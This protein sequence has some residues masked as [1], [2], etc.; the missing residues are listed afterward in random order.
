VVTVDVGC[1]LSLGSL[2]CFVNG[3]KEC[4]DAQKRMT[5]NTDAAERWNSMLCEG[6]MARG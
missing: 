2:A 1:M 3:V 6:R 4:G 5:R